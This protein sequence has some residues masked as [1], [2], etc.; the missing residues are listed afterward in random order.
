MLVDRPYAV[1]SL[2]AA[3]DYGLGAAGD[4]PAQGMFVLLRGVDVE[5]DE[6]TSSRSDKFLVQWR[7]AAVHVISLATLSRFTPAKRRALVALLPA[8]PK[9]VFTSLWIA[10]CGDL[11]PLSERR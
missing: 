7:D 8:E 2:G 3:Q 6:N 9:E 4:L 1:I 10:R 5:T 11:P